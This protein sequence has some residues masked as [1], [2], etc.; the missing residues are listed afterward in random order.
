MEDLFAYCTKIYPIKK[1]ND[2]L[3]KSKILNFV[4][5]KPVTY[6]NLH[7]LCFFEPLF[8]IWALNFRF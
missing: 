8:G 1:I 7:T 4:S 2:T 3:D 5:T 6:I